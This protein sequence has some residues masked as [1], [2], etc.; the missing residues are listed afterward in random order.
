M[1]FIDV[2]EV[3]SRLIHEH[4]IQ[5]EPSGD[6]SNRWYHRN[7]RWRYPHGHCFEVVEELKKTAIMS[8][9]LSQTVI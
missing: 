2:S 6:H 9:F 1:C 7:H 3:R 5:Q 8:N 4:L